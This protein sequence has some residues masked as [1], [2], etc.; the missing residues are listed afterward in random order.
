MFKN[1]WICLKMIG[2]GE[3]AHRLNGGLGI[4]G[5]GG[6]G[7]LKAPAEKGCGFLHARPPARPPTCMDRGEE[8]KRSTRGGGLPDGEIRGVKRL[9][10]IREEIGGDSRD[11]EIRE[12]IGR[13]S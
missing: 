12:E 11:E 10:E 13:D 9:E 1:D 5:G 2:H 4:L 6:R 7:P 8:L 3:R